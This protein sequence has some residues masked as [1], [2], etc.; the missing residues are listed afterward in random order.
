MAS[1]RYLKDGEKPAMDTT[2]GAGFEDIPLISTD[3]P[4]LDE[5]LGTS[6]SSVTGTLPNLSGRGGK[7][8]R[9]VLAGLPVSPGTTVRAE[10]CTDVL[11]VRDG[12]LGEVAGGGA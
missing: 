9:G 11:R 10:R 6:V 2:R 7:E 5:Q 12:R 3:Q 1:G 8:L 4:Y